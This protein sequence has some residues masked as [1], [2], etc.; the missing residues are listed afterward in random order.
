MQLNLLRLLLLI[1]KDE[2][3][4]ERSESDS[5]VGLR[6]SIEIVGVH[7]Q[8]VGLRSKF[9]RRASITI[10]KARLSRINVQ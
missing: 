7:V 1:I 2:S 4:W 6:N 8:W 10:S 3:R 9:G 5:E